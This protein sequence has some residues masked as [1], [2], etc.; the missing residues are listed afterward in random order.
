MGRDRLELESWILEVVSKVDDADD[1][2]DGETD[3]DSMPEKSD[4]S[5]EGWTRWSN[6]W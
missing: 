5:R 6:C 3:G 1:E 2:S 4:R